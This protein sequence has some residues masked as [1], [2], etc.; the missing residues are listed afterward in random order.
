M[1]EDGGPDAPSSFHLWKDHSSHL[2]ELWD[3][4]TLKDFVARLVSTWNLVELDA[5]AC[6]WSKLGWRG[7]PSRVSAVSEGSSEW[8]IH[9]AEGNPKG[10]FQV[11]S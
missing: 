4:K 1:V 9:G 7:P 5:M 10:E 6:T 2:M 3:W 8:Y 11:S